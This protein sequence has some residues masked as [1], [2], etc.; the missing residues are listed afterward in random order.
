M[1]KILNF[2]KGKKSYIVSVA[3]A[4]LGVLQGTGVFVVPIWAWP[5]IYAAGLGSIRSGIQSIA[6]DVKKK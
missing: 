3:I 6:E 1:E 2:L 4:T 5:I